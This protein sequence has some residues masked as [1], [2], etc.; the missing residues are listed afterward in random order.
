MEYILNKLYTTYTIYNNI[1]MINNNI[2][3]SNM[4]NKSI[5][6]LNYNNLNYCL[7]P[8]NDNIFPIPP[9]LRTKLNDNYY[10]YKMEIVCKN[11]IN[12]PFKNTC[13][14]FRKIINNNII[15]LYLLPSF[16]E[17]DY[18]MINILNGFDDVIYI[19]IRLKYYENKIYIVSY[20]DKII[21]CSDDINENEESLT[22]KFTTYCDNTKKYNFNTK[23]N[24][25]ITY[26]ESD[27]WKNILEVFNNLNLEFFE[28]ININNKYKSI[29]S[30][31]IEKNSKNI[32]SILND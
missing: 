20:F 4:L 5:K 23:F 1:N 21:F 10:I 17:E 31:L 7:T 8:N 11:K 6:L 13:N 19:N 26:I 29:Y 18:I 2:I 15:E 25:E 3:A 22:K 27:F 12:K 16:Y 9:E 28:K 30:R 32:I 24:I 14:C